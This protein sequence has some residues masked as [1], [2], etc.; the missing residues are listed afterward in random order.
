MSAQREL[1]RVSVHGG[2]DSSLATS[3]ELD[4]SV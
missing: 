1:K 4:S 2:Q 3:G